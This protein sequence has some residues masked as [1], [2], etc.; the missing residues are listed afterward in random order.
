M[1]TNIHFKYGDTELEIMKYCLY[2]GTK[3]SSS[4][5]F[6]NAKKEL[7]N[8]ITKAMYE[9][10]KR[11][12][13]PSITCQLELF[14]SMVKPIILYGCETWGF[15]N[16]EII[17]RLHLKL[18]K[19]YLKTST[20]DYMVYC[21]L[22]RYPIGIDIKVRMIKLWCKIIIGKQSTFFQI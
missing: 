21:E 6:S 16:N 13:L 2:L 14:D 3:F 10:L 4:V 9:V 12:R 17:D 5:S 19:L 20:P 8:R 7:V 22:G 15:R 18:C 11:G 1:P